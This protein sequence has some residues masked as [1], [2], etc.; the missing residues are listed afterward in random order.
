MRLE[1]LGNDDQLIVCESE[2][3]ANRAALLLEAVITRDGVDRLHAHD[4]A[5]IEAAHGILSGLVERLEER[6]EL[7]DEELASRWNLAEQAGVVKASS[8][9]RAGNRP[10]YEANYVLGTTSVLFRRPG[11]D[12]MLP[13]DCYPME[14]ASSVL[15]LVERMALNPK[16]TPKASGA[17]EV[18][19]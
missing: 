11:D 2:R 12:D 10:A 17:E 6:Q 16:L 5:A 15:P 3:D 7:W 8:K 19:A 4:R 14:M 1:Q 18:G 9:V 13:Y